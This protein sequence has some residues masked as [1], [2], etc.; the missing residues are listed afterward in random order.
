MRDINTKIAW[1]SGGGTGIGQAGAMAM[2]Q[3]G[4]SVV[5]SGRRKEPLIENV[6]MITDAGG[7]S[8]YVTLD[9]G[10]KAAC[11][12][13]AAHI[14]EKYGKVDILVN[15][16]ATNLP[17]RFWKNME[18]GD[19]EHVVNI[20]I[21]G[22]YYCIAA[23]LDQMRE[24]K[25]GLIINISSWAGAYETYLS[26]AAYQTTKTAMRSMSNTLNLEEGCNGI[27]STSICPAEVDTAFSRLRAGAVPDGAMQR[28]LNPVDLGNTI[29]F[30]A[31]MPVHACLNEIIISPTDNRWYENNRQMSV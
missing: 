10:D 26:G 25:D 27:R 2:A 31:Q 5:V 24:N 3:A 6:K 20:N 14:T 11:R 12:K 29:A 1:I 9:I 30:V 8:D 21:N 15:N 28:A 18:D 19:W 7:K 13:A 23:V 17:N 16:A 22:A 4:A